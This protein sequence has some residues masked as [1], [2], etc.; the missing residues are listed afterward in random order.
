MT[1]LCDLIETLGEHLRPM[2][3]QLMPS[4]QAALQDPQS[5]RVRIDAMRYAVVWGCWDTILYL[6]VV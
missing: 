2:W 5:A 1:I 3:G 6:S 4:L